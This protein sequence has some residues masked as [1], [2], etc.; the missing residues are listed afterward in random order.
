M[1]IGNFLYSV[2]ILPIEAVIEFVF[3]FSIS[4]MSMLGAGGA[5]ILVSLTVNFLALPLYNIADEIQLKERAAQKRMEKWTSHIKKTFKGDEQYM[6]LNA[7]YRINNYSPVYA[8]RSSLSILIEIPFFIA[9]YNYL[10]KCD[11][12]LN[13]SF[14]ILE[15]LGKPDTLIKTENTAIHVLPIIMTV[16]NCVSGFVYSKDAPPREK[17]QI[18]V[19]AAIFLFLLYD[20]PSGLVFYWILNNLFSLAKNI[21]QKYVKKPGIIVAACFDIIFAFASL[22]FMFFKPETGF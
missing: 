16:I 1:Q 5:I 10:S 12:L 17:V 19:L 20:S 2:I 18:Y 3:N 13:Q 6:M 14:F 15:N 4:K 21:I 8:L 9:A 11:V 22:Y 7:Y